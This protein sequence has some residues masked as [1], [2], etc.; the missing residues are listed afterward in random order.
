[1]NYIKM[2]V[3]IIG[4]SGALGSEFTRQIAESESVESVFA[5]SR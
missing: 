2:R 3:A 1:M 4:S 5:F